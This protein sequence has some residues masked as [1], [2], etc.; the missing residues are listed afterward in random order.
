M[1]PNTA[2]GFRVPRPSLYSLLTSYSKKNARPK[3][4]CAR[5]RDRRHAPGLAYAVRISFPCRSGDEP[6]FYSRTWCNFPIPGRMGP[7]YGLELFAWSALKC[8][9][10][11]T[12]RKKAG[13]SFRRPLAA[14]TGLSSIFAIIGYLYGVPVLL[15]GSI[16]Y[17]SMAPAHR[18]WI[19]W[20]ARFRSCFC[21]PRSGP[22]V[23]ADQSLPG[24]WLAPEA[25]AGSGTRFLPRL[26]RWCIHSRLF[27]GAMVRLNIRVP[28][29]QPDD[30]CSWPWV[31]VLAFVLN[32][33]E[34]EKA[35]AQEALCAIGKAFCS[36]RRKWKQLV[37]L[38]GGV[39]HDF[40]NLLAV[41]NGIQ[42]S[43]S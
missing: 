17:T 32:R 35:T 36:N 21:R 30:V 31:W 11:G 3:W 12:P 26:E 1:K 4:L 7:H 10:A 15:Y 14:T 19:S 29:G 2:I 5:L 43:A 37:Y 24:G 33:A 23:G 16:E 42:R 20:P 13:Q 8:S 40:N 25:S 41:I 6:A 39:A 34:G 18:L 38:A 27:F 22:D 9:A 28:G